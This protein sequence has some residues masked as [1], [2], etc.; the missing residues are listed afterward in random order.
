MTR[1][2]LLL[3]F[4]GPLLA[5]CRCPKAPKAPEPEVIEIEVP[6]VIEKLVSCWEPLPELDIPVFPEP[7]DAGIVHVT[8]E[9]MSKLL[10]FLGLVNTHLATLE[11]RCRVVPDSAPPDSAPPPPDPVPPDPS[12]IP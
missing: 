11:E 9:E 8:P 12:S 10:V 1:H 4:L 6:V 2:L 3:A 5:G 7:D